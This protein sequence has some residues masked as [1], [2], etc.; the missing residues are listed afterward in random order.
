MYCPIKPVAL[1]L[2]SSSYFDMT[3]IHESWQAVPSI[4]EGKHLEL[5]EK[6]AEMRKTTTIF[7]AQENV[8]KVFEMVPLSDVKVVI[9]GQDPYHG[10]R[11]AQGF[12]FSVPEE[13]KT[14]PSLVNIFKEIQADVYGG[15]EGNFS[16]DLTRWVEQGVFLLNTVLTVEARKAGSHRKILGWEQFTDDVI[17][18]I[19]RE[20]E[21][22][23]FMLWGKPAQKKLKLIDE[24]RHLVLATSHPSP[25]GAYRGFTGS[26]HFSK[27]NA[28]LVEHG[29]EPINW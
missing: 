1:I 13:V 15:E 4:Q 26:R 6:V 18:M 17:K 5:L 14:P 19:S 29:K 2:T 10:P 7:P 22:C 3:N 11:Q 8:Y 21:H 28:Y 27:A 25:L 20:Q 24:E 12:S 9:L 16:S 23:V